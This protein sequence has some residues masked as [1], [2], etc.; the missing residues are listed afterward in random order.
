MRLTINGEAHD[1]P[2]GAT[3]A[4]MLER[5]GLRPETVAVERNRRVVK[6]ATWRE[7]SLEEG[8]AVEVLTFVGGG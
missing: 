8:D 1:L 2:D 5:L 3:V 4:A 6:R 7:S